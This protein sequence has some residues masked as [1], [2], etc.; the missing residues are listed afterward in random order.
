MWRPVT[1][2]QPEITHILTQYELGAYVRTSAKTGEGVDVLVRKLLEGISWD[3]LPRITTPRI[4][5]VIREQ[6]LTSKRGGWTA[7]PIDELRRVASTIYTD[8][9]A[10][11]AE[12]AAIT[13]A[14]PDA[15][16]ES[17]KDRFLFITL[18]FRREQHKYRG[19]F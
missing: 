13:H 5:Q 9:S 16:W 15:D 19:D 11:R 12:I 1:A 17:T 7:V 2:H 3:K 18:P 4:F 6:L 10:I 14:L 8:L